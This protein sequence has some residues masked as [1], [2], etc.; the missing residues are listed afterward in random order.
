MAEAYETPFNDAQEAFFYMVN[1]QRARS[2]G[3]R[4]VKGAGL[5]NR[6]CHPDDILIVIDRLYRQ[7]K[8]SMDHVLILRHY[9]VRQMPPDERRPKEARAAKLWEEAMDKL[10]D[11]LRE[12]GIIE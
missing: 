10:T 9:G 1:C 12:K 11:A 6:P 4:Y 5:Y 3:A 2:D 8:I 7:R